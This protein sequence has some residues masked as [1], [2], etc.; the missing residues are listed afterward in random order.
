MN[1]NRYTP[2]VNY[3]RQIETLSKLDLYGRKLIFQGKTQ[4]GGKANIEYL[5]EAIE[6]IKGNEM[7][8]VTID[9]VFEEFGG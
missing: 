6:H 5:Q 9:V 8:D 3:K 1:V 7:S 2:L 4:Q